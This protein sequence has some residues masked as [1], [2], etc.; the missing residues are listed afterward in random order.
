M[1]DTAVLSSKGVLTSFTY[2]GVC[3]RFRT[4]ETLVRYKKILE[5]DNGYIVTTAEYTHSE[6]EEY[7]DLVPILKNLYIDP[8]E[9]LRPIRKVLI[10][11]D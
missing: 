8:D 2:G 6:V 1:E 9:F 10:K 11:Y 5:W 7:I 3:I 4:P